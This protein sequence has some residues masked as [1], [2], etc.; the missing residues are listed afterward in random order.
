M[1]TFWR[2]GVGVDL[3]VVARGTAAPPGGE[4][5][6][7]KE[8]AARVRWAK[9]DGPRGKAVLL[10]IVEALT[11]HTPSHHTTHDA[12][13]HT[14]ARGLAD[15]QLRAYV[16][17]QNEGGGKAPVP[18]K[19]K[20]IPPPK[21]DKKTFVAIQ[22]LTDEAEPKPVPFKRYRIEL[23][24][25]SVREGQLDQNGAAQI[26]DIDPGTCKVSFPDFDGADWK[27]A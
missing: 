2:I 17:K 8:G 9:D 14:V 3:R 1:R 21:Q 4:L 12:A 6:S 15:G 22:L 26:N 20:T 7:P 5:L 10:E 27:A 11:G 13:L 19:P 24:D 18:D 23:P 16:V 25:A